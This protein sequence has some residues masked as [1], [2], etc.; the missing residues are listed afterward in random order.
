MALLCALAAA[1]AP[2]SPGPAEFSLVVLHTSDLHG[3]VHPVDALADRD[4][5]EGLARVAAAVRAIRA[6]G[7]PTLLVDSGDTIQGAPE[8]A[9]AFGRAGADDPIVAAM[10]LVGYDA[11]ALGNHEFDFGRQ[12][13]EASRAQARFPFLSANV[14]SATTGEPA[15]LPYVVKSVGPLRVGILGLTTP[16]VV[17]WEPASRIEGL[18]FTSAVDATRRYVPVLRDKE[19]CDLVVVLVHEGFERDPET[20]ADRGGGD[21]NQAYALATEVP[22]IDLLLTGHTHTVIDPRKLGGAWVSQPGRFGNTLTRFDV[23]LSRAP[24][25]WSV[26][27]VRGA[28]LPM[29]SVAADPSVLSLAA[30]SHEAALALLAQTVTRLPHGLSAGDARVADT[31]LLD[32]L[33]EVQRRQGKADLSFASLLPGTMPPWSAG[34]LTIREIWSFY[35]FENTLVT[36]RATGRQV[37]QALETAARCISGIETSGGGLSWRRNP[38]VWGYNCDTMDG[39]E[40]ALDPTRPEGQR[41]LFLRRGGKPVGEDDVFLVALNSYRAAGGGG[42]SVW[43]ACARV[44]ETETSLRELLIEDARG[45]AALD[46]ATNENWFLSPSLPEGPLRTPAA[47]RPQTTHSGLPPR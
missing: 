7:L 29:K 22:G 21:E 3:R 20:G 45:R 35:P 11:M 26:S 43:R 28:N 42:Y 31:P 37:R 32:W 9:V 18:R 24:G 46:P 16:L 25:G 39:A 44:A 41:V 6:E 13:L 34:A 12:R 1:G 4:Y 14:L 47:P 8:Q 19:H 33:H 2:Q 27:E 10:N 30:P 17:S 15:F 36:V 5:G 38:A 40:Y 23:K